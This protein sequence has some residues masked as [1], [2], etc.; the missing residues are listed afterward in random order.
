MGGTAAGLFAWSRLARLAL[1][2]VA[3]WAALLASA[4]PASAHPVVLFTDPALDG[5]TP[6]SP[7]AVTLVFNEAVTVNAR[8]I[9]VTDLRDR[10]IPVGAARTVKDGTVVTAPVRAEL[11]PGTYEVRWTAT[12][13]DGHGVDGE[14]RFAI[15]TAASGAGAASSADDPDWA[16][17]GLR[18]L[19]LAGFALAFGGLIGERITASA[20]RENPRLPPLRPWSPHGAGLGLLAATTAGV[21]LAADAE[22]PAALWQAT[23][24]QVALVD[25]AGF[26]LALLLMTTRAR[27]WALLPLLAIPLAE[28][29]A[30]HSNVEMPITGAALTG[31][32]LAAAA[33]WAGALLHTG[34]SVL[35]WRATPP[36]V[37]WV[38]LAYARIAA[39]VF[40]LVVATGLTM[41]LLL[42]PLPALITTPYGQSLLIKLAL[43]AAATALALAGRWALRRQRLGR[44][45]GTVRVEATTLVAVLAATAVLV[46]TPT[47]TGPDGAPPPPAP[48]GVAVP[49]GGLAGQ[50]GVNVVASRGQVVVRLSTPRRGNYY[51]PYDRPD[52]ELS[53]QLQAASA[54][55]APVEFR[56]CGG[57][58]FVARVTW[59]DG[60]NVLTL[61][62]GATSWRGGT[63]AAVIPW[64][65]KPADDLVK[66]TIRVMRELNDFA[67]YEATTSDTSTAMPDPIPLTVD[68]KL[69]LSNEPYN[70]GVAPIAAQARTAS[71]ATRLLM[72]FPAAR[73]HASITLDGLGR[74]TEETLTG[75]KHLVKRRFVYP[76]Q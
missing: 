59:R 64:P 9:T 32:H 18:W 3:A 72:G 56:S 24:G 44:V 40:V 13:V 62:A 28:G 23:P 47:P 73:A 17:A 27:P 52:Y 6:E 66:R 15:G 71:G 50:I 25:A 29:V 67:L 35:R 55:P 46:S 22:S 20:R 1:V 76:G 7:R 38:L 31:V 60:G 69:F 26:L 57:G 63:Y 36:A 51:G 37:R 70:S 16:A 19:L 30:S 61:H 8:A 53:G 74:I 48:H 2:V 43:V 39:W 14:F 10:N 4:A 21:L 42:V 12:G 58:C 41:A 68:G 65:A 54:D 5:A 34:R 33:T 75:P 11:A 49:A 45:T